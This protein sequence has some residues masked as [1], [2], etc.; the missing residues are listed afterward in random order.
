M[1]NV[2]DYI[3]QL[4][5]KNIENS[6]AVAMFPELAEI[7]TASKEKEEAGKLAA[8]FFALFVDGEFS[9]E[10]WSYDDAS[11]F[12]LDTPNSQGFQVSYLTGL[13]VCADQAK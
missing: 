9:F 4:R 6:K 13:S 5:G 12:L 8:S 10:T 1:K 3:Q 11:D 2:N 7:V